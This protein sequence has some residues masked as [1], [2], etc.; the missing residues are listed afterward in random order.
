MTKISKI[1]TSV[2]EIEISW[3]VEPLV[4]PLVE[5]IVDQGGV[6]LAGVA[7]KDYEGP[8]GLAGK[9]GVHR[10]KG[11]KGD[12]ELVESLQRQLNE[13]KEQINEVKEKVKGK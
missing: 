4:E 12:M 8:L 6:E 9:P 5:Q 2:V 11:D 1:A 13:V 7:M 10:R 3:R